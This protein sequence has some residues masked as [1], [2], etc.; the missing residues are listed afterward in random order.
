MPQAARRL[1]RDSQL[2]DSSIV[3]GKNL[4]IFPV[5]RTGLQLTVPVVFLALI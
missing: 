1:G 3:L 2:A 4:W 5:P